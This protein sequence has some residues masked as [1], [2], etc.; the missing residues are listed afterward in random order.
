M[1]DDKLIDDANRNRG[2][3]IKEENNIFL[4]TWN[5]FINLFK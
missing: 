5:W 3:D 1:P 2:D 4:K